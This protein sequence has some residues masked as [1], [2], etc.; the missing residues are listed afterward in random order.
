[1]RR[2]VAA[3]GGN[4][5]APPTARVCVDEETLRAR[6]ALEC[7]DPFLSPDV[8]LL[9]THGNGP[10]VGEQLLQAASSSGGARGAPLDVCVARTQGELGYLLAQ[11]LGALLARRGIP[12]P[13]AAVVTQVVVDAADPAFSRPTKAIGPALAADRAAALRRQGVAIVDEPGRGPRRAVPS[14]EPRDIVELELV[15]RLLSLGAVVVAAGGGGVPVVS[16]ADGLR[17]VEAVVD[18]DLTASLLADALG[19][20]LLLL[21]TD[22]PCAYTG[23]GTPVQAA[24]QRLSAAEARALIAAREFGAGNM[25]PKIEA[26]ARFASVAGRRAVVCDAAGVLA[27]VDGRAGTTIIHER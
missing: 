1:M 11:A 20:E 8:E 15:Q 19:A 14:P 17:G 3:F 24:L 21:V 6:A 9:V 23:F 26:C 7:L 18:K 27:A 10:Q 16:A 25:A 13:V 2:I 5:L 22:V 12:R 4:A